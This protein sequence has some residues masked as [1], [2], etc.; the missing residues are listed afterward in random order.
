[1]LDHAADHW[2]TVVV[3]PYPVVGLCVTRPRTK[4]SAQ[5]KFP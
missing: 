4:F 2:Y 1:M 5:W 3:L